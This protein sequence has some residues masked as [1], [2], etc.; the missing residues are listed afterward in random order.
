MGQVFYVD[1]VTGNDGNPGSDVL[2][3]KTI[4][5][6]L[7]AVGA[8]GNPGGLNS[9]ITL[10]RGYFTE[11]DYDKSGVMALKFL[12]IIAPL[13]P[14]IIDGEGVKS[15]FLKTRGDASTLFAGIRFL[16]FTTNIHWIAGLSGAS[17]FFYVNCAF[18]DCGE[19]EKEWAQYF[20]CTFRDCTA[21]AT[22]DHENC[23]ADSS[24]AFVGA[25]G[26][27]AGNA[28]SNANIRGA[29]ID[30]AVHAPP[31]LD[32]TPGA[33]DLSFDPLHA[34]YAMYRD[35]GVDGMQIGATWKGGVFW[36]AGRR[37]LG[38]ATHPIGTWLNDPSYYDP[39]FD[40]VTVVTGVNDK[41]DF[42]DDDGTFIATVSAAGSPYNTSAALAAAVAAAMNATAT[43]Q[44]HSDVFSATT[45]RH[46]ITNTTGVLLTMPWLT[47]PNNAISIAGDLGYTADDA[48]ATFYVADD[49][50]TVGA[51]GGIPALAAP[52]L[53]DG[54]G[55]WGI[56][57][58]IEPTGTSA[59]V[60]SP[61]IDFGDDYVPDVQLVRA[62]ESGVAVVDTTKATAQRD[63]GLRAN[64]VTFN[65][66]DPG[67]TTNPDWTDVQRNRIPVVVA[68]RFQQR[69][70]ILRL[71]G[72][73]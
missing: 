19:P 35:G 18:I 21:D 9:D 63:S 37:R 61:V 52:A 15:R 36:Y 8:L 62:S 44:T 71:D 3:F 24:N 69:R 65:R 73:P 64:A 50:S 13:G 6:A 72:T 32:L 67:G 7:N 58:N 60:I 51:G 43:T 4:L 17:E 12:N 22:Q 46:T 48:G 5:A 53:L 40:P 11:G 57:T 33:E 42:T 41:I 28:S 1:G 56:N 20:N 54:N 31:F 38:F 27:M 26:L 14:V 66:T 68:K 55:F 59:R 45:K 25:G 10:K 49:A 39:S 29:G 34:K 16:N 47:G 30:T 70:E 23:I 2:P